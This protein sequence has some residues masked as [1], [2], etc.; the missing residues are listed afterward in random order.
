MKPAC[1]LVLR[2]DSLF[3]PTSTPFTQNILLSRILDSGNLFSY[4]VL[5]DSYSLSFPFIHSP[6]VLVRFQRNRPW[7]KDG[8]ISVFLRKW[9][10]GIL[11]KVLE[12]AGERRE[13]SQAAVHM[14]FQAE[15][16]Q[17]VTRDRFCREL[18]NICY[19]L[20]APQLEIRELVFI[21]SVTLLSFLRSRR[22]IAEYI[23]N[24]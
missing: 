16:L 6:F 21:A 22:Y 19:A 20:E 11:A 24:H 9:P 3:H 5:L 2:F 23:P 15:V 1:S 8:C 13:W 17:K 14:Q 7:A 18:W 12:E 4:F 10:Q